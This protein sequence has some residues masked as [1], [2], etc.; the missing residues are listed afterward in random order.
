MNCHKATMVG[1]IPKPRGSHAPV[2]LAAGTGHAGV[3]GPLAG[4]EGLFF[5]GGVN[6][7]LGCTPTRAPP[8]YELALSAR[9]A[10]KVGR[11]IVVSPLEFFNTVRRSGH[12]SSRAPTTRATF[13]GRSGHLVV[14]QGPR[15][16]AGEARRVRVLRTVHVAGV[17]AAVQHEGVLIL[18]RARHAHSRG[19]PRLPRHVPA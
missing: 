4:G 18:V 11:L 2:G 10:V 7:H 19:D 17:V 15:W 3:I 8:C 12:H 13:R 5:A 9:V 6:A 14:Y 16:V 1:L